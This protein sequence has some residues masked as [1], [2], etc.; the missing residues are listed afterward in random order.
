MPPLPP[1][2]ER[3]QPR[4]TVSRQPFTT[5]VRPCAAKCCST[6]PNRWRSGVIPP[7]LSG[8]SG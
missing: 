2:G 4:F 6:M 7:R 8:T 5:V 3:R 1:S